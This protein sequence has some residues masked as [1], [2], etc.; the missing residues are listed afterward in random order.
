MSPLAISQSPYVIDLQTECPRGSFACMEE[1]EVI[2]TRTW[3]VVQ[4]LLNPTRKPGVVLNAFSG[5]LDPVGV[6]STTV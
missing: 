5:V 4:A 2:P 1:K 6:F 3:K